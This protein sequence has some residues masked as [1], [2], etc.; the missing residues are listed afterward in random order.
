MCIFICPVATSNYS[1]VDEVF[2]SFFGLTNR[3]AVL[4]H[5]PTN[6]SPQSGIP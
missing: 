4:W 2:I 6:K 3:S 5:R 1:I